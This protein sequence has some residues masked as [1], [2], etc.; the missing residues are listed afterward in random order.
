[1]GSILCNRYITAV[2]VL[3]F[4]IGIL[5]D[6]YDENTLFSIPYFFV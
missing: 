6:L 2:M 4:T 1:M 5:L 3:Y